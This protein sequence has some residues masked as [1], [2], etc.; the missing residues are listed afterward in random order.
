MLIRFETL[1]QYLASRKVKPFGETGMNQVW[2]RVREYE[3]KCEHKD[4]DKCKDKDKYR[5]D[6]EDKYRD[7]DEDK[8]R[9]EDEDKYRDEDKDENE[10]RYKSR[11]NVLLLHV[12]ITLMHLIY[13]LRVFNTLKCLSHVWGFYIFVIFGYS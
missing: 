4:D 8:Y 10:D 7:E 13:R 2:V 3:N 11:F 1:S 6:D 5:D 9:D 12:F